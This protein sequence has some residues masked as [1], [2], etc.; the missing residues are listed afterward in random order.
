MSPMV[1]I[2]QILRTPA[3]LVLEKQTEAKVTPAAKTRGS[4]KSVADDEAPNG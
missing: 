2:G 4:R 1:S 3:D